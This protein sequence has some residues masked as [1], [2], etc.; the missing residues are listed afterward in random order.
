MP[1]TNQ[2][3]VQSLYESYKNLFAKTKPDW[4]QKKPNGI[5]F[6]H[7][8]IPFVGRNY[9]K[10]RVL[11]YASAENL[12]YLNNNRENNDLFIVD[13]KA[14]N[15]HRDHFEQ[16]KDCEYFPNVHCQ[17]ISDGRL[18]LAAAYICKKL[19]IEAYYETPK[20]FLE[21]VS[22]ANFGKFSIQSKE[23]EKKNIDYARN[24]EK[25][26]ASF[27][28]VK[29]DLSIL[30]PKYIIMPKTIFQHEK[31]GDL[32]KTYSKQ[33]DINPIYQINV[34]VINRTINRKYDKKSFSELDFNLQNWYNSFK[35]PDKSKENYRSVFT[36]LDCD[37][38]SD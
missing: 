34:G 8:T 10:C 4:T 24:V 15:R 33:A 37:T 7:P 36:Y 12:T 16:T 1:E 30:N 35:W 18:T 29:A 14:M 23:N 20:D 38:N 11:I 19:K 27:E 28:Y 32:L 26:S 2:K 3:N 31:V 9:D 21:C 25:L 5:D 22:F 6:I 13:D 17:P